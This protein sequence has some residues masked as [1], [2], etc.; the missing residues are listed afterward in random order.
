MRGNIIMYFK[1][2]SISQADQKLLM[3]NFLV[4][5]ILIFEKKNMHKPTKIMKHFLSQNRLPLKSSKNYSFGY[6]GCKL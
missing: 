4:L 1:C 5:F 3:K 6:Y 2:Q